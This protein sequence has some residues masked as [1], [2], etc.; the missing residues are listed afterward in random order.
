LPR[1]RSKSKDREDNG[2]KA[3]LTNL[4]IVIGEHPIPVWVKTAIIN[5]GGRVVILSYV[6]LLL[7]CLS[8]W[9]S[10]E[11][12]AR[13]RRGQWPT[14]LKFGGIALLSW[15]FPKWTS[16]SKWTIFSGRM[17]IISG[18]ILLTPLKHNMLLRLL[19]IKEFLN[20]RRAHQKRP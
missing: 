3:G 11:A 5:S 4:P 20:D 1:D 17:G 9:F 12:V 15:L 10:K 13:A 18:L 2:D 14:A 7:V 19:I 6:Q 16:G 8:F